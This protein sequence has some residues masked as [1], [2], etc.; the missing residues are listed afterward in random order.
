MIIPTQELFCWRDK[1]ARAEVVF[2]NGRLNC[3]GRDL[4]PETRWLRLWRRNEAPR[5]LS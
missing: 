2:R 4:Q 5:W 1:L 3:G